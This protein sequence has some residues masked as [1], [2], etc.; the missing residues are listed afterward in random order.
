MAL[1]KE[2][3]MNSHTGEGSRDQLQIVHCSCEHL[4]SILKCYS[5]LREEISVDMLFSELFINAWT[6]EE[7][8]VAF[9]PIPQFSQSLVT[10][11]LC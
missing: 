8:R 5:L 9:N 11:S 1:E 6:G 4:Q 2:E 10:I 7:E 3:E